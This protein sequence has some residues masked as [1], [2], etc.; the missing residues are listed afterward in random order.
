MITVCVRKDGDSYTGFRMTGHAGYAEEGYDIVC[1]G[2]SALAVNAVNSIEALAG[3]E[4]ACEEREGFLDCSFPS[5]LGRG[6]TLLMESM[7]LG[8][9]QIAELVPPDGED[10]YLTIHFEEVK[11]C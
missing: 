9:R 7:L 1:A 8:L 4:T 3:D 10:P 6:G 2:A 5:G 11:S